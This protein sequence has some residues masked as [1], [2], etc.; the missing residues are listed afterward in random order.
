[1]NAIALL[2]ANTGK[3]TIAT[4]LRTD[5]VVIIMS[6]SGG[7]VLMRLVAFLADQ[8]IIQVKSRN[9]LDASDLSALTTGAHRAAVLGALRWGINFCVIA[10]VITSVLL[11]LSLPSSALVLWFDS[12][13]LESLVG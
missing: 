6:I 10:V 7:H 3:D 2:A 13:L 1:M 4:W 11:R 8:Q 9:K 12:D 5:L